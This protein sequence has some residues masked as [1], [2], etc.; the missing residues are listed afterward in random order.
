MVCLTC[1]C[2]LCDHFHRYYIDGPA[3]YG[4]FMQHLSEML[5]PNA[6]FAASTGHS[7]K[8]TTPSP[9][10]S[11]MKSRFEFFESLPDYGFKSVIDYEEVR[12]DKSES[13]MDL[14]C[15]WCFVVTLTDFNC[16]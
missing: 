16:V 15:F 3:E 5:A 2:S 11:E 1:F 9:E 10:R 12:T 4:N 7:P 8:L 13:H 6:V 14:I